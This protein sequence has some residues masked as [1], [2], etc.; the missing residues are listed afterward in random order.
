M[1][2]DFLLNKAKKGS[3]NIKILRLVNYSI[4]SFTKT[5]ECFKKIK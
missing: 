2:Y 4:V 5:Q 1:V 3:N